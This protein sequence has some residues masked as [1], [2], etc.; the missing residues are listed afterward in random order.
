MN[1]L[2][3]PIE[4]LNSVDSTITGS[5]NGLSSLFLWNVITDKGHDGF[6]KDV[7]MVMENAKYLEKELTNRSI[8]TF[9]NNLSSTVIFERPDE[10]FV[11]KWQLACV[12]DIAHVVI[13]PS[14]NKEKI[15]LFLTD[16]DN[17]QFNKKCVRLHMGNFCQCNDCI[18]L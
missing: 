4:Y 3:K 14:I 17:V 16:I 8:S 1:P 15:D 6:R 12:G 5:R 13:M 7:E 10:D 11:I 2:L 9:R 18:I